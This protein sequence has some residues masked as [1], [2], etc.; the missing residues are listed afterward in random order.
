MSALLADSYTE[1]GMSIKAQKENGDMASEYSTAP[2]L[3]SME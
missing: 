3:F 2:T 1:T